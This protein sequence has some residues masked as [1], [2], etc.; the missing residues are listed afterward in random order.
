MSKPA[1]E[2]ESVPSAKV[3]GSAK[4][5]VDDVLDQA[6]IPR[7]ERGFEPWYVEAQRQ[8]EAALEARDTAIRRESEVELRRIEAYLAERIA[9][10]PAELE[11]HDAAIREVEHTAYADSPVAAPIR[12]ES[13]AFADVLQDRLTTT[14]TLVQELVGALKDI[15][16][17]HCPREQPDEGVG[18]A[19]FGPCPCLICRAIA[20]AERRSK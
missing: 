13:E 5:I 1:P 2:A 10:T 18:G 4:E 14:E 9:F 12:R 8:V 16:K 17:E 19:S 6:D 20:S 11:A 7:N 3:W 15:R